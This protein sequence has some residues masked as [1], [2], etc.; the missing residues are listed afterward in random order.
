MY[1][2]H[3]WYVLDCIGSDSFVLELVL[4]CIGEAIV[5]IG[6]CLAFIPC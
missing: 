2:Y 1:W 4:V 3:Q 6:K 5:S